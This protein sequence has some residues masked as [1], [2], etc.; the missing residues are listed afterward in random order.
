ML[1]FKASIVVAVAFVI[2]FFVILNRSDR[3]LLISK[4]LK[5][6]FD[7]NRGR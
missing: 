5:R 1:I 2:G 4:I 7:T 6:K 3:Q